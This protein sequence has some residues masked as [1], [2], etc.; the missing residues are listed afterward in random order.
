M[1][2]ETENR[3]LRVLIVDDH[4]VLRDS[5]R[6]ILEDL[7]GILVV[8]EAEAGAAAIEACRSNP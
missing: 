6:M 7:P 3:R 4:S 8:D 2:M 1:K 5:L